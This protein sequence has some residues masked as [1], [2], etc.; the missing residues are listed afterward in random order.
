MEIKSWEDHLPPFPP[1]LLPP[2][3]SLL[4]ELSL[5][6]GLVATTTFPCTS[7]W[8]ASSGSTLTSEACRDAVTR[9]PGTF[10]CIPQAVSQILCTSRSSSK[11]GFKKQN[12]M[13]GKVR[14]RQKGKQNKQTEQ[15]RKF[16]RLLSSVSALL[17]A[18]DSWPQ[19]T[20]DP[21]SIYD[22]CATPSEEI[23]WPRSLHRDR[24]VH[25]V[26]TKGANYLRI[27]KQKFLKVMHV[28]G[29]ETTEGWGSCFVW[30]FLH[31]LLNFINTNQIQT[32][33]I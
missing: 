30:I 10:S 25:S 17:G 33:L 27:G 3:L 4:E 14:K 13:K 18:P 9:L 19:V 11:K 2:H 24:G 28:Y 16:H 15:E 22:M 29:S 5:I 12:K 6:P 32:K 8:Q 7:T 1:R 21:A 26:D 23:K 20:Q 31:F